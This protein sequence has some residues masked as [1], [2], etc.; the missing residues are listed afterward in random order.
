M[1]FSFITRRNV[2]ALGSLI[3]VIVIVVAFIFSPLVSLIPEPE[4]LEWHHMYGGSQQDWA[5]S[6]QNTTDGGFILAGVSGSSDITGSTNHGGDDIYVIK[7]DST[8]SMEW[9]YLYGGSGD[10]YGYEIHQTSDGGYILIGESDSSDFLDCTNNGNHDALVL[11]LD[12]AGEV[13]W[14]QMY[15]GNNNDL[16]ITLQELPDGGFV[17]A[18]ESGSTDIQDCSNNG[19]QDVFIVQ[20]TSEGSIEWQELYGGGSEDRALCVRQTADDGLI[21]FG[22]SSSD[23]L[24]CAN[25]GDYD[26]YA[27]RLNTTSGMIWEQLYGGSGREWGFTILETSDGGYIACGLSD[28]TDIV[29]CPA[30]GDW[31]SYIIRIDSDG[32]LLWQKR[33][34]GSAADLSYVIKAT[35]D[36]FILSGGSWSSDIENCTNHGERDFYIYKIDTDGN[37]LWQ[38]LYGGSGVDYSSSFIQIDTDYI[39]IAGGSGSTNLQGVE[40]HGAWDVYIIKLRL[41]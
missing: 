17:V 31:D 39:I 30:L 29:A 10:D 5:Y 28:S 16:F 25:L 21:V 26:F 20:L 13:D 37:L 19:L 33:Y 9:Q 27:L 40:P 23:D 14:V 38:R 35:D 41:P 15:G 3:V 36:G 4:E 6:V 8:G 34:G 11:K 7:L 24:T 18:G 2:F 1:N 32:E 12:S 22:S